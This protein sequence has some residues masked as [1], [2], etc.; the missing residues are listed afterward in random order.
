MQHL[1]QTNR[2]HA[3]EVCRS[4]REAT[5]CPALWRSLK[6]VLSCDDDEASAEAFLAWLLSR[7]AAV[8]TLHIDIQD[9][10][11][12]CDAVVGVMSNV[13]A[14]VM[15]VRASLRHFTIETTG[16]LVVGQWA[17]AL[18]NL[19]TACFIGGAVLVKQG[20]GKLTQLRDLEFG[21]NNV[22]LE[23]DSPAC[24]PVSVTHLS[25]EHCCLVAVPPCLER[26]T[27][28]RSLDL[29]QNVLGVEQG[30]ETA[31]LAQ[32][33]GLECLKLANCRMLQ[34]PA[35]LAA[36]KRLRILHM[37]G[38][39]EANDDLGPE[40]SGRMEAALRPL[41][42]LQVLVVSQ[43]HVLLPE[44]VRRMTKLERLFVTS[45]P[46]TSLSTGPYC[47]SLRHLCLDWDV[48][49]ESAA[50]LEQC[51]GMQMLTLARPHRSDVP[52]GQVP[53]RAEQLAAALLRHPT[54]EQVNIVA[55][56]GRG[57]HLSIA[58]MRF[59][60]AFQSCRQS[61]LRLELIDSW[62]SDLVR[63]PNLTDLVDVTLTAE[64]ESG[65]KRERPEES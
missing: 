8:E 18:H 16:S 38:N 34:V 37:G 28:L 40:V 43:C 5:T 23:I 25:L 57:L 31:T 39:L 63:I 60:L 1:P 14:A 19:S 24:L 9:S 32:F 42:R 51:A 20:L 11:A 64:A 35:E 17:A 62:D 48:A 27:E 15:A 56:Q 58:T 44:A 55:V 21:S 50:M 33:T 45:T 3:S 61:R 7:A 53:E 29:S 36:L 10:A 59:V 13:T 49:F 30:N 47:K 2:V 46:V 65:R 4:W 12:P 54:L 22:S 6:F 52:D 26:L 41:R